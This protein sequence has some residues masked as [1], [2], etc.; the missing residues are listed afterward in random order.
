MRLA[1]GCLAMAKIFLSHSS[2]DKPFVHKLAEDLRARDHAIWLDE[3]EIRVGECI[4]T[5]I[6]EGLQESKFVTSYSSSPGSG[7]PA[8]TLASTAKNC[9]R[10]PRFALSSR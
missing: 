2:S 4:P 3:W 8:G 1:T 7:G 10:L 6:E 9:S 5:R